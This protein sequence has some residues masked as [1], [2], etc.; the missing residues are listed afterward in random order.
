MDM[1]RPPR[2]RTPSALRSIDQIIGA[3]LRAHRQAAGW[4]QQRLAVALSFMAEPS[5]WTNVKVSRAETGKHTFTVADLYK[6]ALVFEV[7]VHQLLIPPQHVVVVDVQGVRRDRAAFVASLID[8]PL[9]DRPQLLA[10][11]DRTGRLVQDLMA[12]KTEKPPEIKGRRLPTPSEEWMRGTYKPEPEVSKEGTF[13]P[14]RK[15]KQ[16]ERS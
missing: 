2:N 8:P 13:T 7:P 15:T 16:P 1:D 10:D 11:R 12:D 14:R 9:F 6:I 3:N 4:T 5:A